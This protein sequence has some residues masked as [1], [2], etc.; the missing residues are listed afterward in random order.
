[1]V[2]YGPNENARMLTQWH[3]VNLRTIGGQIRH[4]KVSFKVH[5]GLSFGGL[6]SE[7]NC[8]KAKVKTKGKHAREKI[9]SPFPRNSSD[10]HAISS[11]FQVFIMS[12]KCPRSNPK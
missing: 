9:C 5:L 12:M 1:M 8:G 4:E 7:T 3:G 11:P 2:T 10:S 6:T